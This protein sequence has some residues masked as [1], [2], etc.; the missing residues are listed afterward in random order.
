[1][2]AEGRLMHHTLVNFS[3]RV[4][5]GG[6]DVAPQNINNWEAC[7]HQAA[8]AKWDGRDLSVQIQQSTLYPT[9][10]LPASSPSSCFC[11]QASTADAHYGI[12]QQSSWEEHSQTHTPQIDCL[13]WVSKGTLKERLWSWMQV[14][15]NDKHLKNARCNKLGTMSQGLVAYQDKH[16]TVRARRHKHVAQISPNKAQGVSTRSWNAAYSAAHCGMMFSLDTSSAV[17]RF[18]QLCLLPL[19]EEFSSLRPLLS[20][21]CGQLYHCCWQCKVGRRW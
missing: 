15:G 2:R 21:W 14:V 3:V 1:M 10:P 5:A 17:T 12:C 7:K 16:D 18:A 6:P 19:R 4:E 8:H 9:L 11:V 13:V 20:S